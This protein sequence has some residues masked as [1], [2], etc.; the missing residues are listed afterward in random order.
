MKSLFN[1]I[2]IRWRRTFLGRK[3]KR[4]N[5]LRWGIVGTGYMAKVFADTINCSE[6]DIVAAVS[7]RSLQNAKCF[8]SRYTSCNGYLSIEEM[9]AKEKLDIVYIAT[10]VECH[11][12]NIKMCLDLG[13]NV[14]SEKPVT[15]TAVQLEQLIH[16]SKS[17]GLFFMEGMWMKCL[18]T[19][20]V[21]EQWINSG[22]IGDILSIRANIFKRN[23]GNIKSVM[24]DFGEYAIAFAIHF[25][26]K[27][28]ILHFDRILTSDVDTD[29]N[30]IM[31]DGEKRVFISL[32]NRFAS[33]SNA[34]IE[35]SNGSI[36]WNSQ[37]NRSNTVS[38]YALDG[39]LVNTKSFNYTNDGF[40]YELAECNRCISEK[41]I[42]SIKV[43]LDSSLQ[44]IKVI[45]GLLS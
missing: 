11:Y 25:L 14:L 17:K 10:P 1:K 33:M 2:K 18:P 39:S 22:A 6:K 32:S 13:C 8:A 4:T 12:E 26:P 15:T 20:Q 23:V 28:S 37:F 34:I 42:E 3:R 5:S 43:P 19:F 40:E 29:W 9:V 27:A 21:A 45:D 30:I 44:V 16:R 36:V 24:R 41:Q 35:G 7:S 38:L 31:A